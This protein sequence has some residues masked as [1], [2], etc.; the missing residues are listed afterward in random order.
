METLGKEIIDF[1]KWLGVMVGAGLI[2]W[3]LRDA[4]ELLQLPRNDPNRNFRPVFQRLVGGVLMGVLAWVGF[5]VSGS[6]FGEGK[7][8]EEPDF[9][10][11]FRV[12]PPEKK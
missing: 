6:M 1:V 9:T 7:F 3:A 8:D 5:L 4:K 11:P 10:A 12:K 2:L